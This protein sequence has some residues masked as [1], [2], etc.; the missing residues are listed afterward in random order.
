MSYYNPGTGWTP[1]HASGQAMD[2][3]LVQVGDIVVSSH[4]IVTPV[5]TRPVYGTT[6]TVTDLS[7]TYRAIPGWAIVATIITFWFFFLGLLWLLVKEDRT[8]GWIQVTVAA[9]GF[10]HTTTIPAANRFVVADTHSRV[11]YARSIATVAQPSR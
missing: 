7:R 8:D 10:A 5:G 4:W 2:P 9:P 6:W 1:A 3:P 11:N